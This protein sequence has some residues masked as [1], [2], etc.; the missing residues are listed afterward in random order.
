[1]KKSFL[2]SLKGL[3]LVEAQGRVR[4]AGFRT[5]VY[6]RGQVTIALAQP[7]VVM[8]WLT[9]EDVTIDST[10]ELATAGDPTQLEPD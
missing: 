5:S 7:N 2:D 9:T 8:L 3:S 10:V 6:G 1:M 4:R